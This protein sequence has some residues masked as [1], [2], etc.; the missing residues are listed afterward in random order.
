MII[1]S[2]TMSSSLGFNNNRKLRNSTLPGT[3]GM[4]NLRM[5]LFASRPKKHVKEATKVLTVADSQ[6]METIPE[7]QKPVPPPVIRS[8]S[9]SNHETP[10]YWIYGI[11]DAT[12]TSV[13]DV[14]RVLAKAGDRVMLVYPMRTDP[15]N[16]CIHM[17]LQSVHSVTGQ[18][19]LDWVEVYNPDTEERKVSQ[20]YL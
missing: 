10:V 1:I 19:S 3:V 20:F 14:D 2:T 12:I 7:V 4:D 6:A 13:D 17:Q 16:G 5:Q 18:L 9:I 8:P 15:R 11:A